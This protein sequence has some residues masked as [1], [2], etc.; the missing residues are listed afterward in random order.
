[1]RIAGGG[2]VQGDP[3][4]VWTQQAVGANLLPAR[5]EVQGINIFDKGDCRLYF[6]GTVDGISKRLYFTEF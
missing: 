2:H 3:W 5:R 4:Y 6:K 1:M